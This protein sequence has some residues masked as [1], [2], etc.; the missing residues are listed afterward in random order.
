M[1]HPEGIKIMFD[2]HG[3]SVKE[4]KTLLEDKFAKIKA[5]NIGEFY[6]ITGRGNHVNANGTRGVLKKILPKLLKPYCQNILQVN[7]EIG[8]YKIIL[9][10]QQPLTPLKDLLIEFCDDEEK[11][12]SCATILQGKAAKNDIE[13]LIA[14]AMIHLH[15]AIKGFDNINEGIVLLEK[16]IELGSLDAEI[17]L[18][19][20]YHEGLI[21]KQQHEK[22][23][24]HFRHAANKDHPLGQYY[25]AVCYLHG[26]GVK[27]NDKQAVY[28]MKKSADQGDAYAQD[29]LG[30]FYLLGKITQQN[31]A[32]GITYKKKAAEQGLACAQVDLAK[33]YAT[34][35]GVKKN[36]LTA[37]DYYL[38]AAQCN[39]PYAVYQVGS[40][41]HT[42][43]TG[44]GP[45]PTAAFG[46][47]LKAAEL[48]DGDGQAQVAYQYFFGE[49]IPQ[50][51]NQ[52][53][54][55]LLKALKQ[56]NIHA[57]YVMA[58]AYL[59]G[60]GVKQ[61]GKFAYQFM[62]EAAEKGYVEAQYSLGILLFDGKHFFN[63][64]PRNFD[65]GKQWLE[66]A[67]MKGH[68]DAAEII[69]FL[70]QE[71]KDPN[72]FSAMLR[73]KMQG[74]LAIP[75]ITP[76]EESKSATTN[77]NKNTEVSLVVDE[78]SD[79]SSQEMNSLE[80]KENTAPVNDVSTSTTS[81]FSSTQ[82]LNEKLE[83]NESP[84]TW[85]YRCN[86]M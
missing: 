41:L 46:W 21:M 6:L 37:F 17:Q 60:L 73:N 30:D 45:N 11:T 44:L 15:Q 26:K 63:D 16:A 57:Y 71:K 47:F 28:W 51:F 76:S 48:N 74:L 72:L 8:A 83:N 85:N 24:K 65:E 40:Y 84:S 67:M 55:W 31:K 19:V 53:M 70:F 54:A 7:S 34:G 23:F 36:Y 64:L 13:S 58:L 10:P 68:N 69:I 56:E 35:H 2:L 33:C 79:K 27:Y 32:L 77:T 80:N 61:N 29:A 42:G 75:K 38:A 52:G 20:I 59:K 66:K 3:L 49:G 82:A 14:L 62:H 39:Q 22:A 81:F 12:I 43:R 9:K 78:D 5:H 50:D 4:V 1:L 18:G 86:I 25:L